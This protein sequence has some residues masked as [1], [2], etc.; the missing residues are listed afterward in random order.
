MSL[1]VV[2]TNGEADFKVG[3][4]GRLSIENASEGLTADDF[5]NEFKFVNVVKKRKTK[6]GLDM[7][8]NTAK[9]KAVQNELTSLLITAPQ[10]SS[11]IWS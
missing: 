7:H 5:K 6:L 2:N 1:K 10:T 11:K 9:P 3:D 4:M 8:S